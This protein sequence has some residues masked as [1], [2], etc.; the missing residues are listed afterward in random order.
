MP[1]IVK[2]KMNTY[3]SEA[4]AGCQK[5]IGHAAKPSDWGRSL[6]KVAPMEL[7]IFGYYRFLLTEYPSGVFRPIGTIC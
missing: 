4:L 6:K 1:V 5:A 2:M 7:V 3:V